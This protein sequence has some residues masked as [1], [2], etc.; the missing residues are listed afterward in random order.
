[1]F[2]SSE[3]RISHKLFSHTG[4]QKKAML[5]THS[6]LSSGSRLP[7]GKIDLSIPDAQEPDRDGWDDIIRPDPGDERKV[8]VGRR[9]DAATPGSIAQVRDQIDALRFHDIDPYV[10][11]VGS[12]VA[13]GQ[14]KVPQRGESKIRMDL[15]PYFDKRVELFM[16]THNGPGAPML[17]ILPGTY[18]SGKGSHSEILKKMALERGMNYVAVPNSLSKE[19]LRDDPRDHPG[20]PR[21]SAVVVHKTVEI[22][23]QKFPSYFEDVSV[24]GYSYGALNGANLVR[25]EEE[26]ADSNPGME[27]LI[28]GGLVSISPPENLAHSMTELD[29]L[30]ELYK[31]GAGSIIGNG[32][33]Y[34]KHVKKYGYEGF[35]QSELAGR[36]TGENITEIKISDKY[37]SKDGLEDM[38]DRVDYDFGHKN[39]P[40]NKPEFWDGTEEQ[41]EEWQRQHIE[42]L[43]GMTY[44]KY[45]NQ[46]MSQ[47]RWLKEHNLNP[48]QMAAEYS[49]SN[50]MKVIDDTP[51]MVLV[52]ADDYILNSDDVAEFR[53]LEANPGELEAVRIFDTGGHVGISW[54]PAVQNTMAD[55]LYAPPTA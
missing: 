48:D 46:Y 13:A 40:M 10:A 26:L 35:L 17:V 1:M 14:I 12:G 39:L 53:K 51:V 15:D 47:D 29:G 24:A 7:R 41:R 42:L 5:I 8:D 25:Y 23:K 19:S 38:V 9:K 21:L 30:R 55:F 44:E 32:L 16:G 52:S 28:N 22:L 3:Q 36:G 34:K 50:A 54:N 20:N 49:F 27:R 4:E 37:G 33:K 6:T 2:V 31:E 43:D 18:G 11:T 45:S